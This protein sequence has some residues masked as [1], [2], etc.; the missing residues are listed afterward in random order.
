MLKVYKIG[1]HQLVEFAQYV[2]EIDKEN[3]ETGDFFYECFDAG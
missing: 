1:R 2:P 3:L